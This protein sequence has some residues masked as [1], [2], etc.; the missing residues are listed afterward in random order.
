M[1]TEK[2]L[3]MVIL[4]SCV[5]KFSSVHLE[6]VRLEHFRLEHVHEERGRLEHVRLEQH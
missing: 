3:H 6:H 5:W 1:P 2:E 4:W